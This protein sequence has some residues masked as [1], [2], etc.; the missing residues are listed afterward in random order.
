MDNPP[1]KPAVAQTRG[2]DK[3]AGML[4]VMSAQIEAA[5][6]ESNAPAAT[7]VETAHAMGQ[8]TQ[9]I[10]KSL[11]DFSG[12]PARVFQELMLLH[13]DMHARSSKAATAIQFHDRLVQCLTHVSSSL[14]LMAEFVS[15]ADAS[16]TEDWNALR[17]RIRGLLSMEEE[18]ALFDL[19]SGAPE[20]SGAKPA[21][22]ASESGKIELF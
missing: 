20:S 4:S 5:L 1:F 19:L 6:R 12:S 8:A 10:A 17:D 14:S 2:F 16:S 22:A 11:F 15:S 3:L 7:L 21:R 18:R 13:D 9:T